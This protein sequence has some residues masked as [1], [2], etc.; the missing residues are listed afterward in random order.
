MDTVYD[1]IIVGSGIAG[2]SAGLYAGRYRLKTLII[3][4]DFGGEGTTA[5]ETLN[6]PGIMK[7]DGYDLMVQVKKQAESVG[8]E[9]IDGR[10]S[11]AS[12]KGHCFVLTVD[13]AEYI[14]NTIILA[15]GSKRRTLGLPREA[16]FKAKG[17]HYCVTCDG[18]IYKNKTI[19]VVGGG[20]A[21][22]KGVNLVAEYV[23][24]IYLIV[25]EKEII[26]EPINL[27]Q[28]KKL[29]GKVEIL[30]ETE[31]KELMGTA[32]LE[33]IKLSKPHEGSD[34]LTIDGLFVEI[35]ASPDVELAQ[36]LGV[37]LDEHGYIKTDTMMRT[38]VDGVFA[39]G[40][41]VNHF[42]R[43]K[44]YITGAALGA[45]AAT[46]AYDDHK[47]HGD[48]CQ[49]HAVPGEKSVHKKSEVS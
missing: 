2:L 6:Y 39:A 33:K 31:V 18:P 17:L 30:L 4:G 22:I 16:E 24:K 8:A 26:A 37:A 23:Q 9:F 44:Q 21:S 41:V 49:W 5:G 38:N 27:E 48:L 28:M 34:T 32:R 40:D 11:T 45:V 25:R 12:R 43:F 19:A 13:G 1:L 14:T 42:G 36:E 29:G 35:G 15:T 20:D 47:I 46:S 7:I 10:V 3:G